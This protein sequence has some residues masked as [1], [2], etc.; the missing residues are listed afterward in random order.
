MSW[1]RFW[2]VSALISAYPARPLR[3]VSVV[4]Q[5]HNVIT[6]SSAATAKTHVSRL[7]IK[8]DP[9]DRAPLTM[10]AYETRLVVPS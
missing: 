9:H 4:N 1:S 8:L 5:L 10:I 2:Q 3:S 6:G 7:L